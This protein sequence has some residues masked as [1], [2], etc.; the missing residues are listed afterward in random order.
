MEFHPSR[1]AE[2]KVLTQLTSAQSRPRPEGP[3]PVS[4]PCRWIHAEMHNITHIY[5]WKDLKASGKRMMFSHN[6]SEGLNEVEALCWAP[7][8]GSGIVTAPDPT[9]NS[10]VV[11]P[12]AHNPQASM[13]RLH[14]LPHFLWLPGN[15]TA[16]DHGL[17]QGTAGL[18]WGVRAP[19]R[20]YLWSH[21]LTTKVHGSPVCPQW[22]WNSW[23]FPPKTHRRGM[24]NLP[25]TGGGSCS[26]GKN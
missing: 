11:V 13:W 25:F 18:C 20:S 16:K 12:S 24:Q 14:A 8:A 17:S 7:L 15:K 5:W 1:G 4:H 6:L 26:P 9:G 22:Q 3:N 10:R 21:A 2:P 19:P 23:G